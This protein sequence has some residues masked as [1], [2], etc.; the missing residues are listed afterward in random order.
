MAP[1]GFDHAV[2]QF[3]LVRGAASAWEKSRAAIGRN[4]LIESLARLRGQGPHRP[5]VGARAFFVG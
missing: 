2:Y 3:Q 1:V 5:S 4:D